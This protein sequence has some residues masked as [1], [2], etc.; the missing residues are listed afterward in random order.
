MT[1]PMPAAIATVAEEFRRDIPDADVTTEHVAGVRWRVTVTSAR[2]RMFIEYEARS[3]GRLQG[4]NSQLHIDGQRVPIATGYPQLVRI[5][6]DPDH[7]RDE[8]PAPPSDP[9]AMVTVDVE[10]APPPVRSMHTKLVAAAPKG[11]DVVVR[12]TGRFWY[13]CLENPTAQM[14]MVFVERLMRHT[15]PMREREVVLASKRYSLQLVIAGVDLTEKVA[16][17]FDRALS[18]IT[19][20]AG[21]PGPAPVTREAGVAGRATSVQVRN[22][23]V[24]RN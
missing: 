12:H 17:G 9:D 8:S 21:A 11:F 22:T 19:A 3:R 5:F 16:G 23:T 20:H 13:V 14:R 10:Q 6:A 7:G 15:R 18:M 24:I 4:K 1:M 2:V